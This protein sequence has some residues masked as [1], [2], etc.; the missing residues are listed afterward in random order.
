VL[1]KLSPAKTVQNLVHIRPI[2][3]PLARLLSHMPHII[4]DIRYQR[5]A[6]PVGTSP[7]QIKCPYPIHAKATVEWLSH[8]SHRPV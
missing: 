7:S 2:P 3:N 4:G 6:H 8:P 1:G 5:P